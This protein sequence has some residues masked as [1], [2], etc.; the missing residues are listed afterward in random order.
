M[1]WKSLMAA[2]AAFS[3][4]STLLAQACPNLKAQDVPLSIQ[5]GAP[6]NCGSVSYSF[7]GV[8]ASSSMTCCP[9]F[10]LIVPPHQ[11]AVASDRKTR[12]EVV[13]QAPVTIHYFTCE[14]DWLV[15]IPWGS[16]CA[17]RAMNTLYHE[18]RL[19]TVDCAQ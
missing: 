19:R 16:S 8:N 12:T 2:T 5:Y 1:N 18:D 11:V 7:G 13:G 10:V 3:F 4:A 9:L 15:I 6:Q 14:Q 17:F